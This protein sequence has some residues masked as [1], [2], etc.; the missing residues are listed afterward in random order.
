MSDLGVLGTGSWGTALAV[1]LASSSP[2]DVTLWGRD[3]DL[4]AHLRKE[5]VNERYLPGVELPS[6]LRLTEDLAEVASSRALMV[7]VP[8]HGF[9]Q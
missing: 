6:A 2:L 7:V 8:S 1:H 4:V 9:R 5:R 3:P